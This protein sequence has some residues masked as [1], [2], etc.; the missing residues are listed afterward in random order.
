[1]KIQGQDNQRQGGGR[2]GGRQHWQAVIALPTCVCA[3]ARSSLLAVLIS[4][5]ICLQ[6][7]A[8]M[9]SGSTSRWFPR[10]GDK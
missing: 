5:D 2:V 3:R 6:R 8:E 7:F 9:S 1:M 4:F 10:L